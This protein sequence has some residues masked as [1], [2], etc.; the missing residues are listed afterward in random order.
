[1]SENQF[2]SLVNSFA[3]YSERTLSAGARIIDRIVSYASEDMQN[4]QFLQEIESFKKNLVS[5]IDYSQPDFYDAIDS[6]T[7]EFLASYGVMTTE[8][9]EEEDEI[10]K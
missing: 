8:I 1:M 9:I 7:D 6:K 4:W 2:I 5:S 10:L 3:S